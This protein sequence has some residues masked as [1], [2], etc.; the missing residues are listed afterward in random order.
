MSIQWKKNRRERGRGSMQRD[1][2]ES[3]R[4]GTHT[5]RRIHRYK[6]QTT[7]GFEAVSRLRRKVQSTD[8]QRCIGN[9]PIQGFG[10]G[11]FALRARGRRR[12]W[13]NERD[14]GIPW[15]GARCPSSSNYRAFISWKTSPP[16]SLSPSSIVTDGLFCPLV[17]G[18]IK[19]KSRIVSKD[20][21]THPL[22]R[23]KETILFLIIVN[24]CR[25]ERLIVNFSFLACFNST[26]DVERLGL[27]IVY[28]WWSKEGYIFFKKINSMHLL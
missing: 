22:D 16:F 5:G 24:P 26:S 7:G 1:W 21:P 9:A 4:V 19:K 15:H 14:A 18:V 6:W 3:L 20:R 28:Y 11:Q 2:H 12:R 10:R 27:L 13:K 23:E 17:Y 25:K 8:A